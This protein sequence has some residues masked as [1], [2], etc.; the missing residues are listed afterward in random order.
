[1]PGGAQPFDPLAP[2]QRVGV[3]HR[4]VDGGETGLGDGVGA[5]RRPPVVRARF[6]GDVHHASAGVLA[7][8]PQGDDLRVRPAGRLVRALADDDTVLQDDAAHGG[9]G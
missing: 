3:A 1:M 7:G 2:N 9:V 4:R 8:L 6:E 5:G